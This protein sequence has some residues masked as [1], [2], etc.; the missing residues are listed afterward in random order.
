MEN[1]Q[2]KHI[3]E[4]ELSQYGLTNY[5]FNDVY[6]SIKH[7]NDQSEIRSIIEA[8]A[9]FNDGTMDMKNITIFKPQAALKA[10]DIKLACQKQFA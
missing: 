4:Q 2:I 9:Y 1:V 3:I 5:N 10:S 8:V 7:H 6:D